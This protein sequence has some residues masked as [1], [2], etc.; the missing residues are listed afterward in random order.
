MKT[1][2]ACLAA[3][4]IVVLSLA[5]APGEGLPQKA[6]EV[7]K[8]A[9]GVYAFVWKDP[10]EN[11]IESNSLFVINDRD[12]L[13][14]DTGM[15]PS[16]ARVMAAELRKLTDRPVRYVVTTHWHDDHHGGNE[17]YRELWPGVEFV[18]HRDTREDVLAQTYAPRPK[19]IVDLETQAKKYA[20]WAESGK[21]DDGKPL[22]PSRRARAAEIAALDLALAPELRAIRETPP[23]FTF[24]DRLVLHRGS[25]T[26]EIL[27]LGRGN[28]RGDVV[29]FLPKERIAATGDLFVQPVPF[30]IASYYEE[31][32]A[33]LGRVDALAADVLV[34]GHGLVQRDR[35]Y[36]RQVQA[37]LVALV[38]QVR[39]AVAAG[40]T[41]EETRDRVKLADWKTKFAGDDTAKQRAF[42][43]FFVAPAVE[44]AWKQ[45]KG[46]PDAP[47]ER[48]G[49]G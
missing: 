41:L 19:E 29:V 38:E 36:L 45:A 31:W 18:A 34:P 21:D 32:V 43:A 16:T 33:T 37:L 49:G 8:L 30:G 10:I 24:T 15:V 7:V 4:A 35:A 5:S 47:V 28:T 26:I 3:A 48:S 42:D 14:V 39:A 12:V 13:V 23:D 44:R 40:A 20:A 27:W 11:L 25:R 1:I 2:R 22:E 6:Y 17:V 46:E 9:D